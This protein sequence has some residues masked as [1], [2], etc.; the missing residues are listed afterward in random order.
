MRDLEHVEN[1]LISQSQVVDAINL[2][3]Q[4]KHIILDPVATDAFVSNIFNTADSLHSGF[5][6]RVDLHKALE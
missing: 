5:V 6:S 1:G 2:V 3:A 4:Y